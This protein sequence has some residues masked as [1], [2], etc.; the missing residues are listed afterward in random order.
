MSTTPNV[1]QPNLIADMI[2]L[3]PGPYKHDWVPTMPVPASFMNRMISCLVP[4]NFFI[5]DGRHCLDVICEHY[6]GIGIRTASGNCFFSDERVHL[7]GFTGSSSSGYP[8][9]AHHYTVMAE[10]ADRYL[11]SERKVVPETHYYVFDEDGKLSFGTPISIWPF[12]FSCNGEDFLHPNGEYTDIY[13]MEGN[14][15]GSYDRHSAIMPSYRFLVHENIL[16]DVMA[17]N[18]KLLRRMRE[19]VF[20]MAFGL[21]PDQKSELDRIKYV[22]GHM[23]NNIVARNKPGDARKVE[24]LDALD[25]LKTEMDTNPDFFEKW[26]RLA[27]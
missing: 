19:D 5:E 24:L 12:F 16:D 3:R 23:V 13:D 25:R 18:D 27:A 22:Y 10:K 15:L 4:E 7:E 17:L 20:H 9:L 1:K 26:W 21:T 11:A 8:K 14:D 6:E 2:Y